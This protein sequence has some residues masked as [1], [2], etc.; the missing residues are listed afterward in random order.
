METAGRYF[1]MTMGVMALL[2]PTVQADTLESK[3]GRLLE[4]TYVGGTRSTLR[5]TWRSLA[6]SLT[7]PRA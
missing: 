1:L 4:G 3:D 2:S 6:L 7:P 5:P